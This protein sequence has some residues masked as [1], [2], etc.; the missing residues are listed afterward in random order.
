MKT[1]AIISLIVSLTV[2]LS[3]CACNTEPVVGEELINKAREEYVLLNSAR[4]DVINDETGESEQIFIYKYDEK[5][6]MTYSYVGKS[7]GIFIAQYNNGFEQFTND[8]G[9]YSYIKK[10]D[11]GFTAYNRDV[12]YPY[13]DKGLIMFYKKAVN[14]ELSYMA[15]NEM[16]T[17]ICHVYDVEKLSDMNADG[18]IL[19][20]TAKYYF[21]GEGNFLYMKQITEMLDENGEK[22]TYSYSIYVTERNKIDTVK[23]LVQPEVENIII[24]ELGEGETA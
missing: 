14:R 24:P 13:A 15:S 22:K 23:N 11:T 16:A 18:A 9:A 5:D 17:E 19:G 1:R 4:V 20:F 6:M 12:P 8:N 7:E 10:G 2:M 3:L 21:D